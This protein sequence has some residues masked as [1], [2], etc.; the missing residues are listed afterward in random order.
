MRPVL[1]DTNAFSAIKK[2]DASIIEILQIAEVIAMSPVVIGELIFGF[3]N[4]SLSKQNRLELQKFLE[5]PRV[6]ILPILS[7]TAH[8]FSQV[9]LSL[10]KKGNPIPSNDVWIAAQA[11]E[12]GCVVC[13]YDK[14]FRAIEGLAVASSLSELIL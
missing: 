7:E 3:D 13:T 1:I 5:S 6:T 8:Y 11:L 4:G 2:G 9:M 10:K 14:H 12:H